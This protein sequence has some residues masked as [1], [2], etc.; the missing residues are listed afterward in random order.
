MN[1]QEKMD[2]DDTAVQTMA[3]VLRGGAKMLDIAC[4][5]CNNP[6][7][8]LKTGE[9]A[10]VVCN[11]KVLFEKETEK[12]EKNEGIAKKSNKVEQDETSTPRIPQT[13]ENDMS[14]ENLDS[15]MR[16]TLKRK[17][18]VLIDKIQSTSDP[19][20]LSKLLGIL[21]QIRDLIM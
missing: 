13:I 4:P 17:F 1:L 15:L 6:I 5:I 16:D 8:K 3:Q 19:T 10:C 12:E 9:K 14:I 21:K 7:F 11:R 2:K 20:H 18:I